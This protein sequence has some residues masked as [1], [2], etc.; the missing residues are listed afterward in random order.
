MQETEILSLHTYCC[1]TGR[2][3]GV[4]VFTALFCALLFLVYLDCLHVGSVGVLWLKSRQEK[5]WRFRWRV[6]IQTRIRR[7][8]NSSEARLMKFNE[9]P[10]SGINRKAGCNYWRGDEK[11]QKFFSD[12]IYPSHAWGR[13]LALCACFVTCL[14]ITH[15]SV[16]FTFFSQKWIG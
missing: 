16:I 6:K 3:Q 5:A 13:R 7:K 14:L 10:E 4:D 2:K 11:A 8:W 15:R 12:K 9:N 1:I